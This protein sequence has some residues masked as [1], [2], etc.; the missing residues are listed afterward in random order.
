M[1]LTCSVKDDL[2]LYLQD[3][4][5]IMRDQGE[6]VETRSHDILTE[7]LGKPEHPGR[8]RTKGEHVT[9]REVFKKPPGGFRSFKE[10][11][12]LLE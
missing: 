4:L 9:Q 12:V 7:A 1:S 3:N 5:A 2:L 8:V 11:Q 10:S 6:F